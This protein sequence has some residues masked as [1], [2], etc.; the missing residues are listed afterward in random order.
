[1]HPDNN[2][3]HVTLGPGRLFIGM[4]DGQQVQ[5]SASG[6][7][8]ESK[9]GPWLHETGVPS[10]YAIRTWVETTVQIDLEPDP[11]FEAWMQGMVQSYN[12]WM[13]EQIELRKAAVRG[14]AITYRPDWYRIWSRTKKK[15]TRKKYWQRIYRAYRAFEEELSN[16]KV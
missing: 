2:T 1:M 12:A 10:P 4:P 16:G 5:L 15:R 3:A 13:A 6:V 11:A 14:W 8:I 7:E 9:P